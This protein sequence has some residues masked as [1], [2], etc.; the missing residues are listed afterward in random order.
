[1]EWTRRT[2]SYPGRPTSRLLKLPA[3]LRT[4]IFEFALRSEKPVV[5][6]RLDQYQRDGYQQ[7]TQPPLT[8][9]CRQ[10]RDESLSI[11]YDCNDIVLHT[12]GT[13]ASDT[14]RWLRCI[15]YHLPKLRQISIWLRYVTLTNDRTAPGGALGLSLQRRT[16]DWI[17]HVEDQ[18]N[19]VTVTKRP[20]A[21]QSDANFLIAAL[22][23]VL[24]EDAF[25]LRSADG[26]YGMLTDLKSMYVKEK[27]S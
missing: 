5:A 24:A 1:M 8:S 27:M 21:V 17:W 10:I 4:A 13:K 7:A 20:A 14:L 2:L 15:E 6:F 25:C 22:R 11:F 19:W 9:V 12:E 26:I 23:S 3:E 16:S 18:W